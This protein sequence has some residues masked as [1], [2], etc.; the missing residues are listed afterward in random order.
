MY[1]N[2]VKEGT[3]VLTR[4]PLQQ[5]TSSYGARESRMTV[6]GIVFEIYNALVTTDPSVY[7]C[8]SPAATAAVK[9]GGTA[10][11]PAAVSVTAVNKVRLVDTLVSPDGIIVVVIRFVRYV[12]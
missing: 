1:F 5:C 10:F 6:H 7:V 4:F 8:T 3:Q 11:D 9:N 2:I 12:W